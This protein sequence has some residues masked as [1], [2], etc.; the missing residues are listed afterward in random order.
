M[1]EQTTSFNIRKRLK[2]KHFQVHI[3]SCRILHRNLENILIFSFLLILHKFFPFL[4]N[5]KKHN[6]I[7]GTYVIVYGRHK[8][9]RIPPISCSYFLF[10]CHAFL[11]VKLYHFFSCFLFPFLNF[12]VLCLLNRVMWLCGARRRSKVYIN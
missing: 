4:I 9:Y 12:H 5:R 2:Q 7:I 8:K 1:H 10:Q 3:S 6:I 11:F